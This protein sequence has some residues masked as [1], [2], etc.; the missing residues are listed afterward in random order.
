MVYSALEIIIAIVGVVCSL[1][2]RRAA[3]NKQETAARSE[4][5]TIELAY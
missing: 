4:R 3:R 1:R 2:T 5:H